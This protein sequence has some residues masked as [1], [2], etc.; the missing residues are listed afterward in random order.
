L[1]NNSSSRSMP[2]L[3]TLSKDTETISSIDEHEAT[4]I[5]GS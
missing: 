3:L 5:F 4:L 1:N 2:V